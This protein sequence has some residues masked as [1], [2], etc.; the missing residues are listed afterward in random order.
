M[1]LKYIRINNNRKHFDTKYKSV[2]NRQ[3]NTN[4]Q[5]YMIDLD[6]VD[7]IKQNKLWNEQKINKKMSEGKQK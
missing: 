7:Y 1:R 2:L 5:Q 6:W 4:S 3:L